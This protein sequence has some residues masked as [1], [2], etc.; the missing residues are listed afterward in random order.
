MEGKDTTSV[1]DILYKYEVEIRNEF[2]SMS[3]EI[4]EAMT[5][6]TINR[7][8]INKLAICNMCYLDEY[9]CAFKDY[10]YKRIYTPQESPGI[11]QLYFTKLPTPF[12]IRITKAWN[13]ANIQ[14]TLGARIKFVKNWYAE[15]CEKYREDIKME[16]TL[17]KNLSCCKDIV[18]PQFGCEEKYYKKH[19]RKGFKK[20]KKIK[21]RYRSPR[22]RYYTKHKRPHRKKK[23]LSECKCYNCGKLGHI[24]KDCK[25]PK[26]P[27]K[28]EIIE[29]TIENEDCVPLEYID[30]EISDEDSIY[31]IFD[32]AKNYETDTDR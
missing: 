28:K 25:M 23:K 24:A 13:E 10:Y 5:E 9:T 8:L 26:I 1:L 31:E 6:K 7:N 21:H 19:I 29:V 4:E 14:D 15:L 27:R 30:Y 32:D 11:R 18:A 12:D 22:K 2:S 20:Y 17:I 3:T 16:K